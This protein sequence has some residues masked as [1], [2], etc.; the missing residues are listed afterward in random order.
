MA[1]PEARLSIPFCSVAG[2]TVELDASDSKAPGGEIVR[3]S[4][5]IGHSD[6]W[7][8]SREPVLKFR[9]EQPEM[10]DDKLVQ[11]LVLLEVTDDNGLTAQDASLTWVVFDDSQCPE[12]TSPRPT[13]DVWTETYSPDVT[14]FDGPEPDVLDDTTSPDSVDGTTPPPDSTSD[15]KTDTEPA[16]PSI[17]GVWHLEVFCGGSPKGELELNIMQNA[18]CTF[19]DDLGVLSGTMGPD[20]AIELKSDI[21][22]LYMG[23]CFGQLEEP[24]MFTV[25]CSSGCTVQFQK[26]PTR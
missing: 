2:Q 26:A 13:E 3:Y 8:T 25:D 18:D 4:F 11:T 22:Q 16:C 20:G 5:R 10:S 7:L 6:A 9:F 23:D 21:P 17:D 14:D 12:G 1:P 15:G 24:E 19:S